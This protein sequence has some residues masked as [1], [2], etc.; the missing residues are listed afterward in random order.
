VKKLSHTEFLSQDL[1]QS[2]VEDFKQLI[3]LNRIIEDAL[4]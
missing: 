4:I 1:V 2:M 3:R